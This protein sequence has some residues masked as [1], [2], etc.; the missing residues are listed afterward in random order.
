MTNFKYCGI[1]YGEYYMWVVFAF[2]SAFFAGITSIL[3]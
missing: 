2:L 1:V 3:A